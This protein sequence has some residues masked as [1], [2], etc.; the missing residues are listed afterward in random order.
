MMFCFYMRE[1]LYSRTLPY[2]LTSTIGPASYSVCWEAN[3]KIACMTKTLVPEAHTYVLLW[4]RRRHFNLISIRKHNNIF[5]NPFCG[6]L[7]FFQ[8]RKGQKLT[9]SGRAFQINKLHGQ[10][11]FN[12]L[13]NLYL[14]LQVEYLG[15]QVPKTYRICYNIVHII[16]FGPFLY[17]VSL[18]FVQ[19]AT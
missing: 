15:K 2:S 5:S 10:K 12:V 8:T 11:E 6:E 14:Y 3:H 4:K 13:L 9:K 17:F 16:L 19:K 7:Y 1:D 18:K